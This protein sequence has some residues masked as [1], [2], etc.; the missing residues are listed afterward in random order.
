MSNRLL[1]FAL[2][3]AAVL[4]A[5]FLLWGPVNQQVSRA[6]SESVEVAVAPVAEPVETT[7]ADITSDVSASQTV[8]DDSRPEGV[9]AEA[10]VEQ[11]AED[12]QGTPETVPAQTEA[13]AP[14]ILR[15]RAPEFDLL[16]VDETGFALAAGRAAANQDVRIFVGDTLA[17]T[18]RSGADGAFV[19]YFQTPSATGAQPVTAET[20]NGGPSDGP[21][22]TEPLYILSSTKPDEVPIIVEP[23]PEGLTLVQAPKRASNDTVTLD[24]ISYDENG[25]VGFAGRGEGA[26]LLYIDNEKIADASTADD[27]SWKAQ[28][29]R[30]I[31]PGVYTLR[32]DQ[33]GE[34]GNV[35]S[36]IETPFQR[37]DIKRGEIGEHTMT[38]QAGNNLWKLAETLYGS[39]ARYTL[40]Y[41]A[42]KDTIRDPDL[43]YPGQIFELPDAAP[44]KTGV[45]VDN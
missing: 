15:A 17:A 41:E 45:S 29:A 11:A 21:A 35:T 7:A 32:I 34:G 3:A 14:E 38:V 20:D 37:E 5:I 1:A 13:S 16:R 39:G 23:A 27:G 4:F 2:A 36:R 31:E 9:A 24:Q 6:P 26:I 8:D 25:R 33:I 19:A 22:V 12:A 40:I 30:V 43:I 44:A 10:E 42:N 28:A 18:T